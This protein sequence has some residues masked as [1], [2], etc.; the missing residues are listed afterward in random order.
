MLLNS[1]HGGE[2]PLPLSGRSLRHRPLR[3]IADMHLSEYYQLLDIAFGPERGAWISHS[4][5]LTPFGAT[6]DELIEAGLIRGWY[7]R[8][9]VMNLSCRNSCGGAWIIRLINSKFEHVSV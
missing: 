9:Y 3:T 8:D 7:G 6:A 4:H 1:V 2:F 5:I